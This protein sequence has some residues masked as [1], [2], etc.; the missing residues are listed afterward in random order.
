[1]DLESSVIRLAL[2]LA[3]LIGVSARAEERLPAPTSPDC[4]ATSGTPAFEG[5][6]FPL[7]SLPDPPPMT[8]VDAYPGVAFSQPIFAIAPP[9]GSGRLFVVERAGRVRILEAGVL[10]ATAFLDIRSLVTTEGNH[11]MLSMAFAP[12]FSTSGL[13]YLYYSTRDAADPQRDQSLTL[14]RM[15]VSSDPNIADLSTRE[16]LLSIP[17]PFADCPSGTPTA[18]HNGG[19]LAFGNDGYL[20]LAIGDGG[21]RADACNLGQ[22][23]G[24]FFGKMLRLDVSGGLS[25]GYSVPA[26]NPF[27]GPGHPLDEIWA[28]G[29]RNPFRF[30]FDRQTGDLWIGDVG[31]SAVEEIDYE[32]AGSAGGRNYGWRRMEGTRCYNP[33]S[34]CYDATLTLPLFEYPRSDG[35]SVT[36]GR[37]YRGDRFPSLFGAYVY[38][39]YVSGN[40]WAYPHASAGASPTLLANL[41]LVAHIA[42]DAAGELLLVRIGDGK[43]Y[44]LE[45]PS[46]GS[47]QLP[48][49]LSA[50]GLFA[51]TA[52]LL[53]APGL[54]EYR[55]NV[56]AWSDHAQTRRWIALPAGARIGFS[57]DRAWDLP[58]G[59]VLVEHFSLALANGSQQR[60]ETRVLVRQVDRFAAYTYRWNGAGTDA[61]LVTQ[62][63]EASYGVDLG[64]GPV[65]LTWTYPGPGDCLGCHTAAAGRVLGLRTRQMNLEWSCDHGT[66]SQIAAWDALGFFDASPGDPRALP[67]HAP[68]GD[69][70]ELTG[71]RA[72]SYLDANCAMCHQ[73]EGPAP[74]RMDLRSTASLAEMNV[75]NVRPTHGAL[76]LADPRRVLPGDH[77]RSVLWQRLQTLNPAWH[78]PSAMRTVDANAAALVGAWIDEDPTRDLDVDGVPDDSDVCSAVIDPL[79]SDQDRDR[80]GDACDNCILVANGPKQLDAGGASQRDADHDGYGNVCDPDLS[81]DGLV[82]FVDL[83]RMKRLFFTTDPVADLDGD[84]FVRFSDLAIMKRSLFTRPGPAAG[85]P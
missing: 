56:D 8:V 73:P 50:T 47:G 12:D 33:P 10:R 67:A 72:R 36:G 82:N 64:A 40:I 66:Q 21:A 58:L 3:V 16:V 39:D 9:D 54:V 77:S 46:S 49:T 1:M 69:E 68:P 65:P 25:S 71:L 85:R 37:V 75:V 34:G 23:D 81:G 61:T 57:A 83:A 7:D 51:D 84:G 5:H 28:K 74:G 41:T 79:Q 17:R 60:L 18:N 27:R 38:G 43:L 63:T 52:A 30:S 6:A 55:V 19:T 15:R 48:A 76:G 24:S 4:L 31:A 53:P 2:V 44:R 14:A 70:T 22:N 32:P 35:A 20:Y 59:A 80:V 62:R 45:A 78:M 29:F 13:F 11:G 42:E 26:T